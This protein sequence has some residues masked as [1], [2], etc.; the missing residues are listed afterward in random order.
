MLLLRLVLLA[1]LC[2]LEAAASAGRRARSVGS[3]S[4]AQLVRFPSLID[5]ELHQL[6]NGLQQGCFS[7]ADL[8]KVYLKRI[9][10]VNGQVHAVTEENPDALAIAKSLDRERASKHIRG[11]LHGIPIL[12]KNN[13]ATLDKMNNTA[14]SYALLGATV[15]RDST[16]AARLRK[17]GA[18]ILGKANLSQWANYRS[19]NSTD[20]WSAI[21]GQVFAAY[22]L[23]QNPSGSSSGSGVAAD[24]GLA[25]A[26]IGTETIGS[27]LS[28]AER[29]NVV[30]IKPTVGLT[31]R[32]L[33]I[34][35][36]EHRDTIGSMARTVRDAAHI[37]QAIAGSDPHD[38]YTSAIPSI[39]D[40]V[41]ACND[42][43][44]RG[45]RIGVPWNVVWAGLETA[46]PGNS[47]SSPEYLAFAKSIAA[48]RK[49]GAHIIEAN[50]TATDASN[51]ESGDIVTQAD[52]VTN[53]AG[54]F[55][56]LKANPQQVHSLSQVRSF[57]QKTSAEQYPNRD[58][59]LWDQAL[60][61]GFDNTD[62]RFWAAYQ[63][64]LR[65][66]STTGILAA[67]DKYNLSAV[68]MP[69]FMAPEWVSGIG[70]PAITVPM[71]YYPASAPVVEEPRGELVE[72]GPS[73]PFGLSFLGRRWSEATLIGLAHSYEQHMR[74]RG[75]VKQLIRP[76]AEVTLSASC[77]QERKKVAY[78]GY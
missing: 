54:Y 10:Q 72:T 23:R 77:K 37:L 41:A 73:V 56:E 40:Y 74:V 31:S 24:L 25:F 63:N 22:H 9:R 45:A 49:A 7:S 21:G 6:Q 28:P 34:P 14:G 19:L 29:N 55:A 16:I 12:I 8:V 17:A 51:G 68:V 65:N 78:Q 39:P 20:G 62:P 43:A 3:Q 75:R 46:H 18:I 30:G 60:S 66:A 38:N 64:V 5:V 76:A 13:I 47:S 61:L 15:P 26:A 53:L 44:L 1:A 59:G 35:I 32:H 48:M 57:T 58:T 50:F 2:V 36:S 4:T 11:P 27:I 42:Q 52:F 69:T 33:V 67:M 71:G 70:A